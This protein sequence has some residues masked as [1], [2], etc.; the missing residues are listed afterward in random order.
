MLKKV[1]EVIAL[2]YH[3]V[4]FKERKPL[5]HSL[6]IALRTEHIVDRKA[7][8]DLSQKVDI[9]EIEKPI[10][11]IH[12]L[13]LAFAELYKTL[14]LTSEA[15]C[16]V[17]YIVPCK[18]FSH[19]AASGGVTYH[20]CAAADK[21]DGTVAR[22]LKTLHECKRHK[23]TCGKAVSRAVETYIKSSLAVVDHFADL[24]FVSYLCDK[25][26]RLKFFIDLH[27]FAPFVFYTYYLSPEYH[28][29]LCKVNNSGERRDRNTCKRRKKQLF[30][31]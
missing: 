14:H 16:I 10:G 20:C 11:I 19:I 12:H 22:L 31:T 26:S 6:L 8:A 5:F 21:R 17:V 23:V 3:I 24:G 1:I 15:L 2:H 29:H 27:F 7:C 4:K 28:M 9:V 13:S 25:A 30:F 18:H